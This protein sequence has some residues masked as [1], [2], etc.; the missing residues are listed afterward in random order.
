M[1]N[2]ALAHKEPDSY[3]ALVKNMSFATIFQG[4]WQES[5]KWTVLSAFSNFS[6]TRLYLIFFLWGKRQTT[7]L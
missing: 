4:E 1:E 6:R 2:L 3:L 5:P 7:L